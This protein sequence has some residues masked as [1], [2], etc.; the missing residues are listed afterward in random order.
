MN[1]NIELAKLLANKRL[2]SRG[3]TISAKLPTKAFGGVSIETIKEGIILS[4]NEDGMIGM[5]DGKK[6][7]ASFESLTAIEG[8]DV[9]RY[10]QA[11]RVKPKKK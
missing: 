11:Y 8:M 9:P 10:A 3:V 2:L 6:Q 4:V 7:H 1:N 5:F